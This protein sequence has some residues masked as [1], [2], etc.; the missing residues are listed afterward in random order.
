[1]NKKD[2]TIG[3][4]CLDCRKTFKKH[5]YTQDKRGNWESVEYTVNC[6]QCSRSMVETGSAFKAPKSNNFKEWEKLSSLFR[7]GYKFN[8]DFGSP[9][10]E[11][12]PIKKKHP[13]VPKSE[14]RK[15]LRK[16]NK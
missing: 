14:F 8:P 3:F 11:L 13:K 16:R 15:P 6:P 5:K 2:I 7:S 1:M 10:E 12:L 9:F 4:A